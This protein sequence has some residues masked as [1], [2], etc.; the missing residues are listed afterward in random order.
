[1]ATD[2]NGYIFGNYIN[3]T[4]EGVSGSNGT[5]TGIITKRGDNYYRSTSAG[6]VAAYVGPSITSL[7]NINT[8]NGYSP[9]NGAIRFTPNFHLNPNA[10][11]AVIA[12]WDNGNGGN[13]ANQSFRIGN[14]SGS[15]AF[16]VTYAGTVVAAGN[17][18]AFSDRRLKT[19]IEPIHNA[20]EKV[21]KL[22]GVTFKRIDTGT[23]GMGLI[24]QEVQK[25]AAETVE[26]DKDGMLS[27]AYGNLV[28]LLVEAIKE[29]KAEVAALKADKQ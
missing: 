13:S 19:D 5:V 16:Y 3:M 1:V 14:G 18:T 23:F 27:V 2:G 11:Y 26:T 28:G 4:D 6:S 22:N 12:S 24:A 20:L 7:G 9:A 21:S 10:G 29:L 8:I 15:D 17:I 25:V